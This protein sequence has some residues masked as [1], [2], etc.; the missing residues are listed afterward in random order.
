MLKEKLMLVPPKPGCY[1]MKDKDG[2]IIYVGKAK[3]LKNR[4]KSYFNSKHTG[5]T[6][7]LVFNI[8]DFEYIITN[9]E[10][11]SFLLEIN[12]I[13]KYSPKYNILLKDDKTYPYIEISIE[14][15]PL[16]RVIRNKNIKKNKNKLYGPYPSVYAARKTVELINRIYPLR[17]C[18]NMHK[19]VCLYYH[20]GECLGYCEHK[21]DK[22]KMKN[23][24]NEIDKFL[25][26]NSEIITK[27]LN[28]EMQKASDELN[29]ELAQE[30]KNMLDDI[31]VTLVKQVIDT[32]HKYNF[33]CFGYYTENNMI[34]IQVL[35]VR[36]GI[37][38]YHHY[39]LFDDVIDN[40]SFLERYIINFYDRFNKPKEII[41]GPNFD[42]LLLKKCLNV[43]VLVPQ[44]GSIK[45]IL[46]VANNNA[47]M[48]YLERVELIKKNNIKKEESKQILNDMLDI[49]SCNSIEIFDNSHLFGTYY[50]GAVVVFENFE[51]IKNKYRK[52]KIDCTVKDDLSAMR[53][54]IYRR[55]YRALIEDLPL[56]D[57]II[58]DGGKTQ[59]MATREVL[60]SLNISTKVI[61]L[62]KDNNHRTSII[63]DDN[64]IE[65]DIKTYND[66][67]IYLSKMQEEVHRYVISYHRNIKS[68]GSLSSV[69][70]N[71]SG[72]GDKRKQQLLKKY[73]SIANMK[74][75]TIDE[76]K[77]ILPDNIANNFYE[78]LKR[79]D[80]E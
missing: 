71:I 25:N 54:V 61:G 51:P 4:L 35:F 64:L 69:L 38:S 17:K 5:K 2:I 15:Y 56:P 45:K 59:V 65:H 16:L 79:D 62:K 30:L 19:K 8:A 3:N 67:F 6:A 53:E 58:V 9:N 60:D 39:D 7:I 75:A 55:Y 26:G 44:K 80:N 50:V 31:Q 27:R 47:K 21:I 42:A 36:E 46:D 29:Y 22:E 41:I 57:L 33:D 10:I 73:K 28:L 49:S 1:L 13:K 78:Y 32:N 48:Q 40:E 14:E 77:E 24:L 23:M 34:S 72:I 68:K 66:L 18:H 20:I 63:V 12:L 43:A 37:I 52:F 76:L 70:D 74:Q 11:E